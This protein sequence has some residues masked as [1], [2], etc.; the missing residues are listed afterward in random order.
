M[1][2]QVHGHA[3]ENSR[4]FQQGHGQQV[5]AENVF[6]STTPISLPWVTDPTS[7]PF[8]R[9]V[10][11]LDLG[12]KRAPI[13]RSSAVPPY[14]E[15]DIDGR[16]DARLKNA[17]K[18]GGLILIVGDSTAGKSR[19][20][21]E[22]IVRS[23]P[24]HRIL[25]PENIADMQ[26][27]LPGLA[28]CSEPFLL[29]LDDLERFLGQNGLTSSIVAVLRR[30]RVVIVATLRAEERRRLLRGAVKSEESAH[31]H[32]VDLVSVEHLLNQVDSILLPRRW[33]VGEIAK[34]VSTQDAR[35]L[36]ASKQADR[37]G[38]SE[39]LAAG[40]TLFEEWQ[41]AWGAGGNARGA[42]IVHAAIDCTRAGVSQSIPESLLREVHEHYLEEAGG[43]LLAPESFDEAIEWAKRRRN[44]VTS[45]LL[46]S[47]DGTGFRVFDYLPDAVERSNDS[48]PVPDFTWEAVK[49]H[50]AN[51]ATMLHRIATSAM[52]QDRADI[53]LQIWENL[54]EQGDATAAMNVGRILR[55]LERT[56]E[57]LSWLTRAAELGQIEA[58]TEL[59]LLF[60]NEAEKEKAQTWYRRA[61]EGGNG[62]AMFHLA[63]LLQ[64]NGDIEE[65]EVWHRKAAADKE[66]GNTSGLGRLL[67]ET[68]R[69]EEAEQCLRLSWSEGEI[70]AGIQ[71][72]WVLADSDRQDEALEV[73]KKVA[74]IEGKAP[75]RDIAAFSAAVTHE[76]RKEYEEATQWFQRAIELG[77]ENAKLRYAIHLDE[78]VDHH[79]ARQIF[80]ELVEDGSDR[81]AFHLAVSLVA[82]DEREEGLI[83]AKRA[84]DAK[85]PRASAL[86]A[87]LLYDLN[88]LAEAIPY[89]LAAVEEGSYKHARI[90]AELRE[91]E[92]DHD[93]AIRYYEIAT[94]A[95]GH[96]DRTAAICS[97][98]RLLFLRGDEEAGINLLTPLFRQGHIHAACWIGQQLLDQ[99]RT[100][101]ARPYLLT[102]YNNGHI[103]AAFLLAALAAA[104]GKSRE[105]TR[106]FQKANGVNTTSKQRPKKDRGRRRR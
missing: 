102:A 14:I 76:R 100:A 44:G 97:L 21:Y 106:W 10:D 75:F 5:N 35:M 89:A 80:H 50:A 34:A 66:I 22:A 67:A 85:V 63:L 99:D 3:S 16:L 78:H 2:H 69:I 7:A 98:G 32:H 105:S 42:A 29:W 52:G 74:N 47:K 18:A 81:A 77:H 73:W 59:G 62:H 58:A 72:G 17:I 20:A 23:M 4:F 91:S 55:R 92:G 64:E 56:G 60:E 96:Q 46:P 45:L 101:D 53:G 86:T 33:S 68:G 70:P 24:D 71:L 104:E 28:T 65:A 83:W 38:I 36:E 84:A 40:P 13:F 82:K 49:Q 12:V 95:N 103:H 27:M 19:T 39:Y 26:A 93:E 9:E 87:D 6:F 48:A 11:P 61:A 94:K 79:A 15:R 30:S 37:F 51:D 57:A 90:V 54:A 31:G 43:F 25:S 1:T 8:V 41:L 88:N